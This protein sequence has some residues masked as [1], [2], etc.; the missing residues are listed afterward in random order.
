MK[1]PPLTGMGS[2]V[3]YLFAVERF[4]PWLAK[5]VLW[6]APTQERAVALTFDDGPDS[7]HT[8][9]LLRILEEWQVAATFFLIGKRV[10]RAPGIVQKIQE[11]GH[12]IGNHSFGHRWLLFQSEEV[13]QDELTK[14]EEAIAQAIGERP[15]LFRPPMG[16]FPARGLDVAER[17]GYHTVVGDVYPRDPFLPGKDRIVK[18]VVS[19]V[20][21][22]SV[23]IL[24]DG[25]GRRYGDRFDTLSAVHEFV[26]KLRD[27]GYRFVTVSE[28][29]G[30]KAASSS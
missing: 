11:R 4:G 6:R 17:L 3:S 27:Q 29:F 14:C 21:P 18:R 20:R 26:P 10:L 5:R 22:G 28:L 12:E 1:R 13:I 8:M 15:K 23:I 9:A 19:R 25:G 7:R 30:L 24:H 2:D 16:L